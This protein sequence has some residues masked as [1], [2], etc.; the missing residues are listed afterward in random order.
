M[1]DIL[2]RPLE[3]RD[4]AAWQALWTGYLT[5][6]KTSVTPEVYD[7]TFTRLLGSDAQDFNAFVAEVEGTLVGLV[8]YLFH[9]HCWRLENVCYLQDLFVSPDQRRGGVGAALINAVY[10]A[11]D[12]AGAPAVYW[13]TQDDNVAGRRLYDQIGVQTNFIRYNRPS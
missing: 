7:A 12:A 2:I 3:A 5:F 9:R 13:L 8:H 11:A 10:G 4:R 1:T 6:Y